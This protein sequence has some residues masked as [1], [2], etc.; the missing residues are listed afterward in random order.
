MD[1]EFS[2]EALMLR[3]MLRR[4]VEKEAR[5]LEGKF[6]T[7]G[8]LEPAERARL[9]SIVEQMGIWGLTAPEEYGDGELDTVT[10]CMLDEELGKTFVPVEYGEVPPLLYGCQGEQI[11][12]YLEPALAGERRAILAIREPGALYPDEWTTSAGSASNGYLLEG[13]KIIAEAPTPED[14]FVVLAKDSSGVSAFLLD[15]VQPGARIEGDENNILCMSGCVIESDALLGKPGEALSL[16]AQMAPARWTRIGAR[17]IGLTERLIEMAAQYAKEWSSLGGL[18]KDRAAVRRLLAELQVQTKSV[19][20]LVYHAAWGIDRGAPSHLPVAE[21]R[22]ATG[23][24]LQKAVDLITMIYG[25]PGPSP[26][27]EIHRLVRSVIPNEA[28]QNAIDSARMTVA[29][30]VLDV[31]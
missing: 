3:D 2:S 25:G 30:E 21:V 18:L 23:D 8:A 16:G 27:I 7:T 13:C 29:N 15:A 24:L 1:F 17:Y 31:R 14:F 11:S 26:E 5:P 20:W 19:R 28:L 12:R 22:L 10:A 4:F 9:R 6:F